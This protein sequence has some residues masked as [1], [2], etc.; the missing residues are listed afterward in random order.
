MIPRWV[1]IV[2]VAATETTSGC[3][4]DEDCSLSGVCTTS[5]A[6]HC[7]AGWTGPQCSRLDRLPPASREAAAVMGFA[8]NLT[9]WGGNVVVDPTTGHHHLYAAVIAGPNGTSCGLS[10][11]S[12]LPVRVLFPWPQI[13][14]AAVH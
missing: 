11:W 5:G 7:N 3:V 13:A 2:A 14:T 4:T 8:P 6:C 9:S 12:V 10:N 1:M